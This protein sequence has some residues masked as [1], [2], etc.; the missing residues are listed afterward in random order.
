[1]QT[2]P[3]GDMLDNLAPST[4]SQCGS[5]TPEAVKLASLDSALDLIKDYDDQK[6]G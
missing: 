5:T 2:L 4:I 6:S 3:S 1:M